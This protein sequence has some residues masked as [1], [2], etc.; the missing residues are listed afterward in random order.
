MTNAT[1][2]SGDS[3]IRLR[4]GRQLQSL[5]IGKSDGSPIFH[6]H[7][8]GSSRLE[9]L[10]VKAEAERLGV[11]LICLDRPGIGGSDER[12]GYRLLDWPDDVVE[13][14]ADLESARRLTGQKTYEWSRRWRKEAA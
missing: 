11:R 1:G 2:R 8:N 14:A 4:D 5:E 7:G 12:R 6:F 10:T 9:V 3:T 13:V